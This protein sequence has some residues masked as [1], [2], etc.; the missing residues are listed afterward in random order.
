MQQV[1]GLCLCENCFEP[2]RETDQFCQYCGFNRTNYNPEPGIIEVG[3]ILAGKYLVGK[4]LGRGGFGVTYLGYDIPANR[5]IAIKEYMPDG[6]VTRQSGQNALT[7]YTGEKEELFKKGADK[8]FEEAKMVSRFNGNPGIVSVY[9]F[10]YENN[11]AYFVMEFLDGQDLK[12]YVAQNGGKI[13]VDKAVALLMPAIDAL[14]VVHSAG[15]LHRDISPDNIFLTNSGETKLLDFGAARQVLGEQSKSLSVVLKQGFAPIEQYQTRGNFGPWSDIYALCATFYFSI[16][17]KVPIPAMDRMETDRLMPPS[18]MGIAISPKLESVIM[19]GLSYRASMRQQS[20][21]EFKAEFLDALSLEQ[22]PIDPGME[23]VNPYS[24]TSVQD[25]RL[26][27]SE[28]REMSAVLPVQG[29]NN[30]ETGN[31]GV[32][33]QEQNV[34]KQATSADENS[35]IGAFV[36]KNPEYYEQQFTK[37][38]HKLRPGFHVPAFLVP[39]YW[40]FYRKMYLAAVTVFVVQQFASFVFGMLLVNVGERNDYYIRSII[41]TC[42]LTVVIAVLSGLFANRVYYLYY[43]KTVKEIE[44]AGENSEAVRRKKSGVVNPRIMVAAVIGISALNLCVSTLSYYTVKAI[45][46]MGSAENSYESSD[47]YGYGNSSPDVTNPANVMNESGY[48]ENEKITAEEAIEN[49]KTSYFANETIE[50]ESLED[51]FE[52][53]FVDGEWDVWE[54]TEGYGVGYSGTAYD[55]VQYKNDV[56]NIEFSVTNDGV[57]FVEASV[58]DFVY[59]DEE[60]DTLFE[61]ADSLYDVII[62]GKESVLG[63]MTTDTDQPTTLDLAEYFLYAVD[64]EY[65]IKTNVSGEKKNIVLQDGSKLI[66][67]LNRSDKFEGKEVFLLTIKDKEMN[68]ETFQTYFYGTEPNPAYSYFGMDTGAVVSSSDLSGYTQTDL[69]IMRNEIFALHGRGFDNPFL[70]AVFSYT[71]WYDPIY[72]PD[73]FPDCLSATDKKN[74]STI[75]SYEESKGYWDRWDF[76]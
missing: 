51:L 20:M 64:I 53:V 61:Y 19:R 50:T 28:S 76:W 8:F 15:I 33:G 60:M 31:Y 12:K 73:D 72:E 70:Q 71:T 49:V 18:A 13:S 30:Y 4:M 5:K 37:I 68:V 16:T 38:E 39:I 21:I 3:E 58:G 9:E 2:M 7:V 75:K 36:V 29:G 67:F 17:G 55:P 43:K 65:D 42:F 66:F 56:Y 54:A 11:T 57:S 69:Y 6:L 27:R 22:D 10:F 41:I 63:V 74:V 52:T 62:N 47:Y 46:G 14:T 40:A 59:T 48:Q 35:A 23:Y 1:N 25:Q 26:L 24:V 45:G 32:G 34:Y 44:S